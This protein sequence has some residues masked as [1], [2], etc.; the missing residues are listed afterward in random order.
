MPTLILL[1]LIKQDLISD[2]P[3]L[4]LDPAALT[5][6]HAGAPRP[7]SAVQE[8]VLSMFLQGKHQS[9]S[10]FRERLLEQEGSTL[11]GT[12]PTAAQS[13]TALLAMSARSSSI[14]SDDSR[15][16]DSIASFRRP[17]A[18]PEADVQQPPAP[19]TPRK[20]LLSMMGVQLPE[21]KS[22]VL[23]KDGHV[24]WTTA[25][26]TPTTLSRSTASA[27]HADQDKTLL[28]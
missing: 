3:I 23:G 13:G 12:L 26:P 21:R 9:P 2:C 8:P 27:G 1:Y 4:N 6:K 16:D 22:L 20:S 5:P 19:K 17:G 15:G 10:L 24:R 18:R 14:G 7:A 11:R 25:A 28:F